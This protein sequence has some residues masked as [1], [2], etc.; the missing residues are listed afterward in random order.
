MVPKGLHAF[1]I[2]RSSQVSNK[3]LKG[4]NAFHEDYPEANY[5]FYIWENT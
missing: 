1:E 3:A 2:K 5:I 4:L